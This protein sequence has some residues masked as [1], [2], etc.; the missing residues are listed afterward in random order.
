MTAV[1]APG[2]GLTGIAAASSRL[3]S[4]GW[5]VE[6]SG[7]QLPVREEAERT[8]AE[9]AEYEAELVQKETGGLLAHHRRRAGLTQAEFSRLIGYHRSVVGHAEQGRP[10]ASLHFWERADKFLGTGT[11]F[12]DR[13]RLAHP[14]REAKK[15]LVDSAEAPLECPHCGV[16]ISLSCGITLN[17]F[18]EPVPEG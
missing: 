7:P 8:E 6:S 1:N 13:H 3:Q 10:D 12:A 17:V 9:R 18:V 2:H 14:E 5:P 4:G 11:L 16:K 15:T